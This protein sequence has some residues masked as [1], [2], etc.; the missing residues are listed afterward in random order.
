MTIEQILNKNPELVGLW[1]FRQRG[2]KPVWCTTYTV[3]G[4]YYDTQG[5]ATPKAALELFIKELK[6]IKTK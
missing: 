4:C 6:K 3:N 1:K 5:K 2:K